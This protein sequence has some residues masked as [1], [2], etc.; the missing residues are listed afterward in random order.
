MPANLTAQYHKAEEAYRRASTPDDELRC[1]QEML[2]EVPKHKGTDRLQ[3]ELK[4][5]ISKLKK[6]IEAQRSSSK[7]GHGVRIPRQGAGRTLIIG[8]P[9]SGKSQ[10]LA[11]LT[12]AS[13]EIAPYPFTTR[14]PQVGMMPWEDIMIQLIDTPPITAD[15]L[16]TYHQGLILGADLVLLV[17]DLGSDDGIEQLQEVIDRLNQTKTRLARTS[18]VDHDDLGLSFT[19]SILVLNKIDDADA[20]G[21][22]ELLHE[23]CDVDLPEYRV[24]A[25]HGT[26]L[27]ELKSAI[28]TALDVVRVYTKEP[29]RKE[30]DFNRPYTINRGGTLAEVAAMIHQDFS[31]HLKFARVWGSQVH[32]GTTVKGDYVLNDKDVVELHT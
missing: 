14:E 10:L 31:D 13:P 26:G 29:T 5:K 22:D 18:F 16:E 3:A 7:R 32:P 30:A 19:R 6:E 23:L 25:A 21:R 11:T 28:Y 2:R 27:D 20:P 15:T 24:S 17:A 12:R 1:L 8:G 9:N 4:Q